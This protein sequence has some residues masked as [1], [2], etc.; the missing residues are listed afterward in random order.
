[1]QGALPVGRV[2]RPLGEDRQ[3]LFQ[4]VEQRGG[5]EQ[6]RPGGREFDRQRQAVE[7]RADGRDR[8]GGVLV[9]R[10]S[11]IDRAS[12][13]GEQRD[14]GVVGERRHRDLML[15]AHVERGPAGGQDPQAGRRRQQRRDLQAGFR[16]LLQVVQ[17]Q[18]RVGVADA[19]GQG[20]CDRIARIVDAQRRRDR[21]HHRSR[22]D[23]RRQ[24][25]DVGDRRV[26]RRR[27]LQRE[28]RLA[29]PARAGEGD[30]PGGAEQLREVGEFSFATHERCESRRRRTCFGHPASLTPRLAFRPLPAG[31]WVIG[32]GGCSCGPS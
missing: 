27:E 29:A 16:D 19:R 6:A 31:R 5:G 23:D 17:H 20:V 10:E 1:M 8:R 11:R 24:I 12:A 13:V 7:P 30:Q 32:R 15:A 4:P 2:R 25:H 3:P 22:I 28:P 9:H 21:R 14:G 18:E 26:H